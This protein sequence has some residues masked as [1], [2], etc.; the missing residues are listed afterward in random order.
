MRKH[1]SIFFTL[2]AVLLVMGFVPAGH[3]Q[4]GTQT[5]VIACWIQPCN[6]GLADP[7]GPQFAVDGTV[8]HT[9]MSAFWPVGSLHTLSI[10]AGTGFSYDQ[11][12]QTQWQFTGWSGGDCGSPLLS[13]V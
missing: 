13:C 7:A 11:N 6:A 2:T 4:T 1:H 10:P 5:T 3:S 9:S 12:Q 8:Y